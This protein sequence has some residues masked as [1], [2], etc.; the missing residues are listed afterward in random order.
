MICHKYYYVF[1]TADHGSVSNAIMV[2]PYAPGIKSAIAR[3][4][5]TSQNRTWTKPPARRTLRVRRPERWLPEG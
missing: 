2:Q 3:D 1:V 5:H 4:T